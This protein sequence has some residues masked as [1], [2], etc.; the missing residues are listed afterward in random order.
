MEAMLQK[1]GPSR[2]LTEAGLTGAWGNLPALEV[3]LLPEGCS[4]SSGGE[5]T[6]H[7]EEWLGVCQA[8]QKV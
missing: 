2:V 5:A 6:A 8:G 7:P 4:E 1:K 3:G